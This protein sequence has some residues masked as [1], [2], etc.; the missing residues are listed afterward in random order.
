M[1]DEAK[2]NVATGFQGGTS[3]ALRADSFQDFATLAKSIFGEAAG[4]AFL[5]NVFGDLAASFPVVGAIQV[6]ESTMGPVGLTNTAIGQAP[7]ST[8]GQPLPQPGAVAQPAAQPAVANPPNLAYPGDCA[9]GVR[10]YKDKLARGKPWRRWECA[11]PWSQG[12]QGRCDALNV[13]N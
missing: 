12:A 4:Q 8:V 3:V 5:E 10:T 13:E 11:V 2:I 1:A 6:I 9:H 7:V